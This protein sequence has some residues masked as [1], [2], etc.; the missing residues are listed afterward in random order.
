MKEKK[1]LNAFS[2]H[3]T[4]NLHWRSPFI[5]TFNIDDIH[6]PIFHLTYDCSEQTHSIIP[7]SLFH[8]F[9]VFAPLP[10][11]PS[12]STFSHS[13]QQW[14]EAFFCAHH[15]HSY[16]CIVSRAC[17]WNVIECCIL[18]VMLGNRFLSC[19]H[20]SKPTDEW[21]M[22]SSIIRLSFSHCHIWTVQW[23]KP[24]SQLILVHLVVHFK[25]FL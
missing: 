6:M 21:K 15:H 11:S 8:F 7:R 3:G 24:T 18:R 16:I 23:E 9:V 22:H 13:A 5:W 1:T 4:T 20:V 2:A 10:L 17:V 19:S 14:Y 12:F 25:I